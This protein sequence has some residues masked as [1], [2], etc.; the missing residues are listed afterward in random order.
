MCESHNGECNTRMRCTTDMPWQSSNASCLSGGIHHAPQADSA[1]AMMGCTLLYGRCRFDCGRCP[2]CTPML[3][4]AMVQASGHA[5]VGILLKPAA[6][7]LAGC[8]PPLV[9]VPLLLGRLALRGGVSLVGMLPLLPA[10]TIACHALASAR[11]SAF[12]GCACKP[13]AG[14]RANT[15]S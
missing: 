6:G 13:R 15:S 4:R 3:S 11:G 5:A 7:I 1:L 8:G 12:D 2:T 9:T 10:S 14:I